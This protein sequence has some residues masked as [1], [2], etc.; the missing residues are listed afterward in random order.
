[1]SGEVPNSNDGPF[2]VAGAV[3]YR[4]GI[5]I[6]ED[7][8]QRIFRFHF[9]G[10][11]YTAGGLLSTS[12]DLAKWA[13]ALDSGRLLS[14]EMTDEMMRGG[15]TG[16]GVGWALGTYRGRR[17]V[18]HSGGRAL[19]DILRFPD[20]K[21][22]IIV[23]ANQSKMYPYLAQGVADLL[24]D[25][26]PMTPAETAI[27]TDPALTATLLEFL[28]ALARG[29]V[30]EELFTTEGRS[31]IVPQLTNFFMP[32]ARSLGARTELR[33]VEEKARDG[34]L[35]RTYRALYGDKPLAWIFELI[36]GK[37]ASL[38]PRAE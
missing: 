13:A 30:P 21:L 25:A 19:A 16:F 20:E 4:A 15:K 6:W 12:E 7:D 18:V 11:A 2:L 38:L 23:L 29:D 24:L 33:F 9:G 37:I 5:Y 34:R 28:H 36:D 14:P 26:R 10:D 1:M 27:D 8:A 22:T 3:P 32:Y 31:G 17:T 35:V